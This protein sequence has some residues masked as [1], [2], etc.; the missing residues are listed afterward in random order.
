VR[1]GR[2]E[3]VATDLRA[4][5]PMPDAVL[6]EAMRAQ[7]EAFLA[8][9]VAGLAGVASSY[10][11]M[12]AALLAAETWAQAADSSAGSD[13][14]RASWA[15]L[16]MV[17]ER[18]CESPRTVALRRRPTLITNREAQVSADASTGWTSSEIA[19]KRFISVR[20]VDN[21]LSS[22]YR[23]LGI[24]GRDDLRELL[25]ILTARRKE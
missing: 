20:T 18:L 17:S 15:L 14:E 11:D 19:E 24:G 6:L 25:G 4:L 2:P 21:H 13:R 3:L 12:G 8:D 7:S 10:A 22:V 23:K 9:D 5:P 1:L 16:S